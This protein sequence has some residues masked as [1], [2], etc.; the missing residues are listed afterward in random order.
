M[1]CTI[2]QPAEEI[3]KSNNGFLRQPPLRP[4][5]RSRE[6]LHCSSIDTSI[7]AAGGGDAARRR[8]GGGGSHYKSSG[9]DEVCCSGAALPFIRLRRVGRGALHGTAHRKMSVKQTSQLLFSGARHG[10]NKNGTD[11]LQLSF[12]GSTVRTK[13][14]ELP[15]KRSNLC[16]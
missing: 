10:T 4:P 6:S 12:A 3:R 13:I 14:G 7:E 15:M 5:A 9:A 16:S 2:M 8:G 1:A 11:R